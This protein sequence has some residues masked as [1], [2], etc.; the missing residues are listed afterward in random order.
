M[1]G[2][3]PPSPFV[4]EKAPTKIVRAFVEVFKN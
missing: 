4:M 2:S 1:A 3:D